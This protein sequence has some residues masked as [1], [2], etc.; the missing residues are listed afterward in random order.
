[1]KILHVSTNYYPVVGGLERAVQYLAEEQAKLSHEV[2]VVTSNVN[3][4]DRP[5]EEFLNG[6]KIVRLNS[7]KFLYN[8][9]TIPLEKPPL[10]DADIVHIHSQNS[11]FNIVLA[12]YAKKKGKPIVMDFLAL[13]Y[14]QEHVNT[15][16]RILGGRYQKWV[17]KK[18]VKLA[19]YAITL[20]ERDRKILREEYGLE[21]EV[22]P[23]GIHEEYLEKPKDEQLF[24]NKYYIDSEN[25]ISYIGRVDESKGV[26]ILIRAIPLI[27]RKIED[28]MVVIVGKPSNSRYRKKVE[29]LIKKLGLEDRVKLIGYISE[30]EKISLL[31]SSKVFVFPT[32]HAGEA[33]PLVV[34]EAYARGVPIIATRIGA[35]P[36]RVKHMETGI[37]VPPNDPPALA[38]ALLTLLTNDNL[39]EEFRRNIMEVKRKL[40]TW[41]EVARK[42]CS[43]YS[44]LKVKIQ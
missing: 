16:I 42:L 4:N 23:H 18:A 31:D 6:I 38:N 43:I 7:I 11:L 13:N 32:R 36:Y 41:S 26:D 8:D 24:R 27:S 20:N 35:L 1:M 39:Y 10:G 29:D 9:L 5:R 25:V 22:V 3:V 12:R 28:F 37:L 2:I 15:L 17:Q 30:G 33:Y 40:L 19:D 14:L 21:S 34:D 44:I